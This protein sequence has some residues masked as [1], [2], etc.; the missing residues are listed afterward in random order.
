MA[1]SVRSLRYSWAMDFWMLDRIIGGSA[2]LKVIYIVMGTVGIAAYGYDELV[3]RRRD[4]RADYTVR[5]V[6][7][8]PPMSS[9]SRSLLP[10][11]LRSLPEP[12][13]SSTCAPEAGASTRSASPEPALTAPCASLSAPS[14]A[15]PVVST[16]T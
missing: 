2:A 1:A 7:R 10:G 5:S 6:Q 8:P 3:R 4:P 13:S 11:R 16:R 9:M 15:T 12:G 14:D